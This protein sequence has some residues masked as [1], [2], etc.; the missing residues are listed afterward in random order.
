MYR[1]KNSAFNITIATVLVGVVLQFTFIRFA[2]YGIDKSDYGNFV[3][4]QALIAGLSAIFLQIPG[5]SF[6]RYF[7]STDNKTDFINEFRSLLLII[8]MIS[9]PFIVAYGFVFEKYGFEILLLIFFQFIVLNNFT[10]NQKAMLFNLERKKY[11]YLK[12]SEAIG[13]FLFPIIFYI[14]FQNLES[15]L[16]GIL[17]GYIFSYLFLIIYLKSYPFAFK[18]NIAAYKKY[19][20]FAY[21]ILFVSIFSWGISFSNRYFIDYFLTTE[22]VAI[23]SLLAS[24][25]GIG[26]IVGQI[27]FL[28]AEPKIL[29]IYHEN[30][31]Y[32]FEELKKYLNYLFLVFV[33]LLLFAIVLP[34]EVYTILLEKNIVFNNNYFITMLILIL[35]IFIHILLSAYH[36]YFKLLRRLDLLSYVYFFAFIV[37]FFCNFFIQKYGI[38]AAAIST[39]LAYLTIF[40]LQYF[41]IKLILLK[42]KQRI[43][44]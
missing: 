39:L 28:Y 21:P 3:L 23:Y 7:N 43:H 25:A 13:K 15:L 37:N 41:F 10:L 17:I 2:S 31:I 4:L 24:V 33:V 29:K 20:I 8:N 26:Q 1:L 19:F 34:R 42:N 22:D 40:L 38:M 6:D 30:V 9:I 35:S 14:Y 12:T 18:V 27:Y 5:Q 16:V 11:F 32:S 36:M 44:E